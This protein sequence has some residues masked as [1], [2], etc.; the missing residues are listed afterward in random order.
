MADSSL[1]KAS[2]RKYIGLPMETIGKA[3]SFANDALNPP[4]TSPYAHSTLPL[5]SI[6]GL[7]D[8]GS[9][10]QD[11]AYQ[12]SSPFHGGSL[13]TGSG[14]PRILS[15]LGLQGAGARVPEAAAEAAWQPLKQLL[16]HGASTYNPLIPN[17]I[18]EGGLYLASTKNAAS[19]AADKAVT[20]FG[21][22]PVVHSIL[23]DPSS[24]Q[25]SSYLWGYP[26][27]ATRAYVARDPSS[28]QL[29]KN[30]SISPFKRGGRV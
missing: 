12:G 15:L 1:K 18:S 17:T 22:D 10:L 3:L 27:G 20:K 9:F 30:G 23:A 13:Q 16:Y 5:G 4:E 7:G 19:K 21:G 24:M 28:L 29:Q 25:D 11:M 6:L 2:L 8:A 26:G 14:D